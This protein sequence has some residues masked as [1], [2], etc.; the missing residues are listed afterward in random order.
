MLKRRQ[1]IRYNEAMVRQFD[2]AK[3]TLDLYFLWEG[4]E[5]H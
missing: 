1:F 4:G 3:I 2:L 5:C